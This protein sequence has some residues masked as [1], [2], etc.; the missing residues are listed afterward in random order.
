MAVEDAPECGLFVC[1]RLCLLGE[2]SDWAGGFRCEDASIPV[3]RCLGSGRATAVCTR[4]RLSPESP[5]TLTMTDDHG[6]RHTRVRPRRPFGAPSRGSGGGF[7]CHVAGT[8]VRSPPPPQ[9]VATLAR[10]AGVTGQPPHLPVKKGLSSSA[11]VCVLA[12]APSPAP[13]T[14]T[15]PS[16]DVRRVRGERTTP[17]RCGTRI[18]PARSVPVD[19]SSSPS[20]AIPSTSN[21]RSRRRR[22]PSSSRTSKRRRHRRHPP[23]CNRVRRRR[24]RLC[25]TDPVGVRVRRC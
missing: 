22:R 19:P 16:R 5:N 23:R 25:R 8:C 24:G 17:S 15:S 20:T 13:S 3:G 7:W 18:K 21:P 9:G 2:H 14:S 11:A 12:R 10:D 4:A 6:E 1:G